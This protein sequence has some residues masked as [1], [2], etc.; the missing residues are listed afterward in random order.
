MAGLQDLVG[1]LYDLVD[2]GEVPLYHWPPLVL[3]NRVE[4]LKAGPMPSLVRMMVA[5]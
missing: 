4:L 2:L 5:V 3:L 1:R